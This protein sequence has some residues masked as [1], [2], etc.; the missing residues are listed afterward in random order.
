M[1]WYAQIG[2]FVVI[3]AGLIGAFYYFVE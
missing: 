1:P 2:V 3:S